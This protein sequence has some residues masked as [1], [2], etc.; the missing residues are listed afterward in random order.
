MRVVEDVPRLELGQL[1]QLPGWLA[2]VAA[3]RVA[4]VVEGEAADRVVEVDLARDRLGRVWLRCPGCSSR[5]RYLH[6]LDGALRCRGA[7]CHALRYYAQMIPGR[8]WWRELVVRP[9]LR[10]RGAQRTASM[11]AKFQ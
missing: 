6:L 4:L 7:R 8:S 1:R 11:G 5:R 2:F 3:G 9:V 10:R